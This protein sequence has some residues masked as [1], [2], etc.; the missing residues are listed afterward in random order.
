M[1]RCDSGMGGVKREDPGTQMAW[2]HNTTLI[3]VMYGSHEVVSTV[4]L[5]VNDTHYYI[6]VREFNNNN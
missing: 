6:S 1:T 4:V 3:P 2:L 5:V